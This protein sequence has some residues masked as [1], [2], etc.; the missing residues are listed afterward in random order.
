MTF[1]K[2]FTGTFS[3]IVLSL[4]L[5]PGFSLAAQMSYSTNCKKEMDQKLKEL[6]S[7]DDWIEVVSSVP[8]SKTFR[9]ATDVFGEW[10][11]VTAGNNPSLAHICS[12]GIRQFA[13][14]PKTCELSKAT[15]FEK[16]PRYINLPG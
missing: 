1:L 12:K 13:W 9:S 7:K 6:R 2:S 11:E 3:L 5:G 4:L 14:N 10:V 8:D 15:P 16:E